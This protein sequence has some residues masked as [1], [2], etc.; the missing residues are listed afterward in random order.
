MMAEVLPHVRRPTSMTIRAADLAFRDLRREA[1]KRAALSREP[2]DGGDLSSPDVVEF[3]N[4][5]GRLAAI[6]TFGRGKMGRQ[7]REI[8]ASGGLGP[9]APR[10]GDLSNPGVGPPAVAVDAHD[11]AAFDF[12]GDTPEGGPHPGEDRDL[13]ALPSHMIELEN[14]RVG[15]PA[16]DT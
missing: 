9:A 10:P 16:V 4:G 8:P 7:V 5:S 15:L 3:E 12:L 13:A 1:L 14:D 11:L 2:C 6:R